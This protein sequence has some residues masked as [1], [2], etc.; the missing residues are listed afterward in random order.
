M[1]A[2]VLF[3]TQRYDECICPSAGEDQTDR[4]TCL[5]SW[6]I[7]TFQDRSLLN[8]YDGNVESA[9]TVKRLSEQ[10]ARMFGDIASMRF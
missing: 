9:T 8:R 1:L 5:P 6:C 3:R 10:I 7:V 4:Q 2:Y